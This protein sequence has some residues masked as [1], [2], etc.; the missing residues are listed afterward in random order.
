M[1]T[2]DKRLQ[3]FRVAILATDDFEQVELTGPRRALEDAGA[4]VEIVA[5]KGG[6]IRGMKH[7]VK[8]DTFPVDKTLDQVS[9][10]DYD[11]ALL[12]GGALNADALRMLPRAQA[13][14]QEMDA[15]GK[16]LAIICHAPWLLVSAGL[17]GGRSLTSYHTIQDDIR[18]AGGLWE[19]RAA[20]HDR[21]WVTSRN[22]NDIPEFNKAMIDLFATHQPQ[23]GGVGMT[24]TGEATASPPA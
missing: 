19:D 6:T 9:A 7:D 10:R 14:V 1:A 8:A 17:V 2:N 22:P 20:V 16:P 13:F 4:H 3:G 23:H 5:P 11:A 24:T 15:A 18:N 21:N 12:P